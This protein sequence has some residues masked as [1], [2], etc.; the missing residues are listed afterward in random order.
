MIFEQTCCL[1]TGAC[2]VVLGCCWISAEPASTLQNVGFGSKIRRVNQF[3]FLRASVST[4]LASVQHDN[5]IL[6]HLSMVS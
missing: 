3:V 1:D 6:E 5:A 4:F 2:V